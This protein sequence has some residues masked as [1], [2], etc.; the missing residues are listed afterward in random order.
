MP[1]ILCWRVMS[2]VEP[3]C[4]QCGKNLPHSPGVQAPG[5]C[6]CEAKGPANQREPELHP[7]AESEI[8]ASVEPNGIDADR[9]RRPI[10]INQE[11]ESLN[12]TVAD[13]RRLLEFLNE[14]LP[15]LEARVFEH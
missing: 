8:V 9:V 14:A 15:Y 13:A 4:Y 5:L 12:L 2:G 7:I 1:E 3:K 10:F 6:A 11:C